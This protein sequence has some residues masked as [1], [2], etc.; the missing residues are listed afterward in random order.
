MSM[1]DKEQIAIQRLRERVEPSH[2]S[3][4]PHRRDPTANA[5]LANIVRQERWRKGTVH[6]RP[7]VRVWYA[8]GCR[9]VGRMKEVKIGKDEKRRY[10]KNC[11]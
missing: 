10:G 1:S 8:P 3:P 2:Y 9:P 5:A 4:C 6:V 7:I 11:K